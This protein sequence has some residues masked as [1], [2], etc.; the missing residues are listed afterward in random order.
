MD[1]CDETGDLTGHGVDFGVGFF[2]AFD[3]RQG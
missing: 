3:G 2:N 1:A